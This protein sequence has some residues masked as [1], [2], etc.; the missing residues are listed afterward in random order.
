M[1]DDAANMFTI[2]NF[3]ELNELHQVC[4]ELG[5]ISDVDLSDPSWWVPYMQ[6][7]SQST[8]TTSYMGK[9]VQIP[10]PLNKP[11]F[12]VINY[13]IHDV[14][15][16]VLVVT[17]DGWTIGTVDGVP[18]ITFRTSTFVSYPFIEIWEA[19]DGTKRL[20]LT[21]NLDPNDPFVELNKEFIKEWEH[22]D[23][24]KT[25]KRHQRHHMILGE[26]EIKSKPTDVETLK[27]YLKSIIANVHKAQRKLEVVKFRD[28]SNE[29]K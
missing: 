15:T 27:K 29:R 28:A 7:R 4:T 20:T 25:S 16:P 23:E 5:L 21:G 8:I 14:P 10:G 18:P 19:G 9:T 26:D 13:T 3:M 17:I 1:L 24:Y 12:P 11:S 2:N 6:K 22:L